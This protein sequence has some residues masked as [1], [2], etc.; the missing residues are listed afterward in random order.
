MNLFNVSE[1]FKVAVGLSQKQEEDSVLP[2]EMI[3]LSWC[4]WTV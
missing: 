3:L 4:L 1:E 2:L